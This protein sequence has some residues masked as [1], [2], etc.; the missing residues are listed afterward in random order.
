MNGKMYD[1]RGDEYYY[2]GKKYEAF[3]K[4]ALYKFIESKGIKVVTLD[5]ISMYYEY[6]EWRWGSLD[7]IDQ[8]KV[9]E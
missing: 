8:F 1:I 6:I 3:E 9:D 2:G 5:E 7:Y 4:S